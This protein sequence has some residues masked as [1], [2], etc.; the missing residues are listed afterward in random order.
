[1]NEQVKEPHRR[2]VRLWVK[3]GSTPEEFRRQVAA[4]LRAFE[5]AEKEQK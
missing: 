1:M 3:K 2:K 5:S 4:V